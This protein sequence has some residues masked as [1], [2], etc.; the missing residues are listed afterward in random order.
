MDTI[1]RSPFGTYRRYAVW[2]GIFYIVATVAPIL[3]L[4]FTGF[5]GRGHCRGTNPGLPCQC[6]GEWGPSSHRHAR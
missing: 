4:S 2:A 3:S 1:K 5:F 6:F